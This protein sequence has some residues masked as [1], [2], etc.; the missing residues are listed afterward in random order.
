VSGCRACTLT[1]FAWSSAIQI[2]T[3]DFRV[4]EACA[5]VLGVADPF[6]GCIDEFRFCHVQ[7]S[8]G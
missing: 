5:R 7:R 2:T 8:D 1:W 3:Q 6:N 4:R